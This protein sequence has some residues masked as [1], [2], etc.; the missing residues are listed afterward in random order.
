MKFKVMLAA[1]ALVALAACNQ[2]PGAA[3]PKAEAPAAAPAP[4]PPTQA[5][6]DA[7][8]AKMDAAI[9]AKD[10]AGLTALYASG[11]VMIDAMEN[12]PTKFDAATATPGIEAWLKTEPAVTP[13]AVETQI[14][15]A[16]TFVSSGVI[17]WDF[18]RN[19]RPT[20]VVQRY[21]D[22]WQKQ[23]DGSWKI[24]SSH[25]S[26]APKPV[27]A[28]LPAL[29]AAAAPAPDTPPLGGVSAAPAAPAEEKK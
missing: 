13:N 14:L 7:L 6:V 1:T 16:D 26:N 4:V 28:R 12:M 19:G 2:L 22:V 20:W 8:Y 25:S 5:D 21:T 18:K 17:T 11:A 3:A 10:V 27:S 29:A 15:D 23:S 9:K 24:V